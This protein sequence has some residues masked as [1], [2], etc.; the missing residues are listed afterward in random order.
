MVAKACTRAKQS[1]EAAEARL[2]EAQPDESAV[3]A[4]ET[5][6]EPNIA[7]AESEIDSLD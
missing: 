2:A 4:N 5:L 6:E 1:V 3:L 7:A